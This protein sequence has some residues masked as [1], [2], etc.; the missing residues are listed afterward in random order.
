MGTYLVTGSC[1][2]IGWRVTEFLLMDGHFVVG[3]DN[4]NSYYDVRLKD[5]RLNR[6]KN[7]NNFRFINLD[8]ENREALKVV[9]DHYR[10]DGIINLAARAGV[11]Y[12]VK[13]PFVYY[14][15]N[16]VGTLNLLDLA[17]S[18]NVR[19]FVHAST[20]SVYAGSSIPFVEDKV[21]DR[22]IS[23]YAVSKRAS[24][25]TCYNY[26]YLYGLD[27]AVLRY[28]TVFGPCGR[29]DMSIFRFIKWI[30]EGKE[31][32]IYGDGTQARDFTYVDDVAEGTIKAL[33][34]VRGFE[35]I[36]IGGGRAP[37]SLLEVVD[38][39]G[40]MLGKRPK[41]LNLP[42]LK[43]DVKETMADITKARNL[44]G[45]E[46]KVSFEEG[47]SRTVKWYIDNRDWLRDVSI[48][49]EGE[50]EV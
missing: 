27:I 48:E 49:V 44:L 36:N 29:P 13:N 41:I 20:S 10:F 4:M 42:P 26:H 34:M 12:S 7:Y 8:I 18:H 39:I 35:I 33:F 11:Q 32:R 25:L 37:K 1:G 21:L 24:E 40:N 3:V 23:P 50:N 5:W 22:P 28:F 38:M 45:W 30:D 2:F 14:S 46:P 15:T 19:K 17:V 47:L 43:S 9:F 31:V 16:I 6:L